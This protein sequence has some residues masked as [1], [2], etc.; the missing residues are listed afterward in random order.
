MP[1]SRIHRIFPKRIKNIPMKQVQEIRCRVGKPMIVLYD[2]REAIVKD[3]DGCPYYITE[4]DLREMVSYISNYSLYA[5]EEE[6]RQGF[7]TIEGGHR[8]GICGQVILENGRIKNLKY[9]SSLNVRIAHEV[10]GCADRILPYL[11]ED[12]MIKHTLIISPPR[13]GKTTL[14]RDIVRQISDGNECQK[15]VSVGVVD[16]RSE[17]GGCYKGIPQNNLGIRTDILDGCPKADGMLMLIRS[18]GP[19]VI[20]VDE[21]GLEEDVHAIEYAMH[22]GCKM[23]ATIHGNTFDEIKQKPTIHRLMGEQGFERYIVLGN[24]RGV[25]S[26][27]EIY[28][29]NHRLLYDCWS[30]NNVGNGKV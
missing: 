6:M 2:N 30:H 8:I 29:K 25:G 23:L 1:E 15:G 7:V 26:V 20:A 17:I 27:E 4:A 12:K 11:T 19:E 14:L 5:F 16:E 18:M 21:I 22:C 10:L 9:I 3:A 28:D 24:K 13:C